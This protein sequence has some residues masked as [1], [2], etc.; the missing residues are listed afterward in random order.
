MRGFQPPDFLLEPQRSGYIP[1][2]LE[3]HE[4]HI[5]PLADEGNAMKGVPGLRCLE[6]SIGQARVVQRHR[7]R[8]L[9]ASEAE[10][11]PMAEDERLRIEENKSRRSI[12]KKR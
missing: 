5:G 8:L 3:M 2:G 7:E 12:R 6:Y 9:Q 4:H 11:L 10:W 1:G